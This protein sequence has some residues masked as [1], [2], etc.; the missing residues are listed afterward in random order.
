MKCPPLCRGR[1]QSLGERNS[2]G[3]TATPK[4]RSPFLIIELCSD[5]SGTVRVRRM[6]WKK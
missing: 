6:F 3:D 4:T 2:L 1:K 5:G